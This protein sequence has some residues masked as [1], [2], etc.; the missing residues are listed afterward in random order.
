[1]RDHTTMPNWKVRLR[2]AGVHLCISLAI[3]VLA[4]VLVFGFWYPYPYR[5][6][7]GGRELFLIVIAVD[8]ILGPLITLAIFNV[9]KPL[10]ELRLDLA[11]VALIQLAGLGYGLWTV[12][13]ARPAHL[14]F[15]IDRFRVVHVVEIPENLLDKAPPGVVVM[16]LSGPT[17][18]AVRPFRD[19]AEKFDATM[20]A[21]RGVALGVRPDLWQLYDDARPAVL[22]SG[23]PVAELKTRWPNRA[24]EIETLLKELGRSP[25]TTLWVPMASRRVFWTVF[26][27]SNTAQVVGF[28]PLDSF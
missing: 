14:V 5:E 7:S 9:S 15:E 12:S 1:M 11:V 16:P 19:E 26:V 22:K 13:L 2:A 6:V 23:R 3:A 17:L 20:V 8:V 21:L 10:R 4:A 24:A 18:L 25:A 28:L 27:D